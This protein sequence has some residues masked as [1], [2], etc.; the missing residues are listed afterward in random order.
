MVSQE[1]SLKE[2]E[3]I[4]KHV[5]FAAMGPE[6]ASEKRNRLKVSH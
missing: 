5:V 2:I 6:K 1:Y 3:K 4:D